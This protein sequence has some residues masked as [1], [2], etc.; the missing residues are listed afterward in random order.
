MTSRSWLA[1]PMMALAA[2]V[3]VGGCA[4][5]MTVTEP[6]GSVDPWGEN[7]PPDP[8]G[9]TLPDVCGGQT[10]PIE[11][12]QNE[13][14]PDLHLVV[15]RSGSME[16]KPIESVKTAVS[17][18]VDRVVRAGDQI[19]HIDRRDTLAVI[20][21]KR[22]V[23]HARLSRRD[24][25]HG[26]ENFLLQHGIVRRG[27]VQER[28]VREGGSLPQ[29]LVPAPALDPRAGLSGWMLPGIFTQRIPKKRSTLD[30]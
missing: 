12:K 27:L 18:I 28:R 3:L 4:G 5:D 17:L 15:D 14:V 7:A 30:P 23:D 16:G 19:G 29:G 10:I 24:A 25:Q 8:Y 13:E 9:G 2:L 20:V 21:A 6:A 1:R 11:L 22:G 26:A